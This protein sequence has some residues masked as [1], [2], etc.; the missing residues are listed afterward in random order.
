MQGSIGEIICDITVP[1]ANESLVSAGLKA[2]ENCEITL[3]T[4]E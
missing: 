1:Q 3:K 4:R 2:L